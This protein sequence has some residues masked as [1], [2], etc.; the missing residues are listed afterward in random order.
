MN[1]KVAKIFIVLSSG[2]LVTLISSFMILQKY[3]ADIQKANK[4][5]DR[6]DAAIK[7]KEVIISGLKD[8]IAAQNKPTTFQGQD[9][10]IKEVA[11][12]PALVLTSRAVTYAPAPVRVAPKPVAASVPAPAPQPTVKADRESHETNDD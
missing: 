12:T 3:S 4:D 11:R 7:D 5:R 1:N 6:Y 8:K 10:T 2:L 9:N